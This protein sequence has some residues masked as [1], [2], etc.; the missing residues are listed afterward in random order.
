VL[1]DG[2][3]GKDVETVAE[4]GVY[5]VDVGKAWKLDDE[6]DP[7]LLPLVNRVEAG[8]GSEVESIKGTSSL[9]AELDDVGSDD[10]TVSVGAGVAAG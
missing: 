8:S 10:W 9:E 6:I 3:G 4:S 5:T 1:E 2:E 7:L